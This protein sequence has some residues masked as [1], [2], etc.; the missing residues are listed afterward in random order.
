M[1]AGEEVA[2]QPSL[3]L[4]FGQHLDNAS[5]AGHVFVGVTVKELSV[6]LFVGDIVNALEPVGRG[7]IGAKDPE[8]IWVSTDHFGEVGPQHTGCF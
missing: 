6:P 3:A 1:T 7:L 4:V 8:V 2:F 5:F